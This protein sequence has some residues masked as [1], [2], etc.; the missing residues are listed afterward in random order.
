VERP[1]L[2]MIPDRAD[3][4]QQAVGAAATRSRRATKSRLVGHALATSGGERQ[5]WLPVCIV[6]RPDVAATVAAGFV[7]EILERPVTTVTVPQ[8]GSAFGGR[9]AVVETMSV[10]QLR[11]FLTAD[12]VEHAMFAADRRTTTA[13]AAPP[14]TMARPV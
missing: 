5:L 1:L 10:R 8:D 11:R 3:E 13:P 9:T 6:A 14:I 12:W 2:S 7:Q 4:A